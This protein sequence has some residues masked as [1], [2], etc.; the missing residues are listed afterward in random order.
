MLLSAMV[1]FVSGL[2]AQESIHATDKHQTAE[3]VLQPDVIVG[4]PYNTK[5][6]LN[7]GGC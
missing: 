2:Q 6:Q 4:N 7:Q 1:F 3:Q 5:V